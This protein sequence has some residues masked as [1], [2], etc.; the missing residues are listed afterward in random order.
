MKA[1]CFGE[2][3]YRA[4]KWSWLERIWK[5][6]EWK[7]KLSHII[8]VIG[9]LLSEREEED[10][11][12]KLFPDG[13]FSLRETKTSPPEIHLYPK[14]A[15]QV[16]PALL[17]R[18]RGTEAVYF[19]PIMWNTRGRGPFITGQFHCKRKITRLPA[20]KVWFK[21]YSHRCQ[22]KKGRLNLVWR[23]GSWFV[24]GGTF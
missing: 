9:G 5:A 15:V 21:G 20:F 7:R 3:Y 10:W 8:F 13:G 1:L 16:S 4:L 23:S 19:N 17:S 14:T 6:E 11:D 22:G 12:H 18:H 24:F 2:K